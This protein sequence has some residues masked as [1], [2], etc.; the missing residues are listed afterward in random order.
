MAERVS[1]ELVAGKAIVHSEAALL[2]PG[3]VERSFEQPT[4][5][6]AATA[7]GGI[8]VATIAALV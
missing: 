3:V 4:G 8:A 5:L 2:P 7:S 1:R 6:Y